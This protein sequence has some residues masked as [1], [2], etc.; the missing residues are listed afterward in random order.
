MPLA[1]DT[2]ELAPKRV[3]GR[4]ETSMPDPLLLYNNFQHSLY[5]TTRIK[6]KHSFK[7]NGTRT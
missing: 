4:R 7:E 1:R 3:M 6:R 2:K 5:F